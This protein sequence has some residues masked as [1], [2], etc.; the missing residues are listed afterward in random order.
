[1]TEAEA[2]DKPIAT[3]LHLPRHLW[4]Y[5]KVKAI[6]ENKSFKQLTTEIL[7]NYKQQ[8]NLKNGSN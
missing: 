4:Q 8:N 5:L 3:N 7:I 2:D 6:R 1:M